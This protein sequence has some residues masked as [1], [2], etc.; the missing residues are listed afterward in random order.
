MQRTPDLVIINIV[1]HTEENILEAN[2]LTKT[3]YGNDFRVESTPNIVCLVKR[4]R[5]NHI[6]TK[7]D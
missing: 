3:Y 1:L 7:T 6:M 4:P 2:N 5:I